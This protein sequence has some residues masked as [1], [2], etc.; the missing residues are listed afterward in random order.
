MHK[1]Q[2]TENTLKDE[3]TEPQEDEKLQGKELFKKTVETVHEVIGHIDGAISIDTLGAALYEPAS[4][5]LMTY[6]SVL[7]QGPLESTEFVQDIVEL[8]AKYT[9]D[10]SEEG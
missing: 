4:M 2:T 5:I 3:H 9:K 1:E 6:V 10:E 7:I 8:C